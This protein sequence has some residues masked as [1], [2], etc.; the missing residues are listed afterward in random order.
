MILQ[1]TVRKRILETCIEKYRT[2]SGVTKVKHHSEEE[3]ADRPAGSN[4]IFNKYE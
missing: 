4:N 1:R 2:S 3:I